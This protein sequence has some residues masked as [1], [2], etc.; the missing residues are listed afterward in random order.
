MRSAVQQVSS[1]TKNAL[2]GTIFVFCILLAV[3]PPLYLWGTR[4][5]AP[6]V[7]GMPFSVAYMLFDA[8][9]LTIAVAVLYWVEDVRG[10]LE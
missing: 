10:E 4:A 5:G 8:I 7:L 3:A 6:Q 2:F 1:S 9:V